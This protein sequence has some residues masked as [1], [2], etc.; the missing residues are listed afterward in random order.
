MIYLRKLTMDDLDYLKSVENNKSF[1]KYSF[2]NQY[3]SNDELIQ[4]IHDSQLPVEQT[5]QI[6]FVICKTQTNEQLG[7]VD[8]FEIDFTKSQ[9]GISI[10][11][12]DTKNRSKGY[13]KLSLKK[14]IKYAKEELYIK[15]LYCNISDD[16]LS[17]INFFKSVGF[18]EIFKNSNL[19]VSSPDNNYESIIQLKCI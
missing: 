19:Y 3:Y 13:G 4:F 10:L 6:R 1:W 17:S 5:N 2:Q 9:T 18:K 12:S 8:L 16:N 7:F 11:I 15:N 14:V